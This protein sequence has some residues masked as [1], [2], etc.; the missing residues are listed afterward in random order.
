MTAFRSCLSSS[1]SWARSTPLR[2]VVG[3]GT[4]LSGTTVGATS[5]FTTAGAIT[6]ISGKPM[7]SQTYQL[8]FIGAGKLAGSVIRGLVLAGFCSPSKIVASEPNEQVRDAL[9]NDTAV[10]VT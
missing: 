5:K 7:D 2:S 9:A 8:G 10:V 6:V 4:D 3:R 1:S